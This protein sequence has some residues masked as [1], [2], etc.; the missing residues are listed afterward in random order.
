MRSNSSI[1]NQNINSSSGPNNVNANI[2]K[3]D[4]QDE[5]YLQWLKN[6]QQ[7]LLNNN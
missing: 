7:E 6:V 2:N 5:R 4:I 1:N 3:F